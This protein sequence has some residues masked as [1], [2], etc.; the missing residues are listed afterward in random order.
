MQAGRREDS[1]ELARTGIAGLDHVVLGGLDRGHLYL[2]EG[3][4]GSGKT[5]LAMQ[6][7]MEGASAGERL[8]GFLGERLDL[9]TWSS[10]HPCGDS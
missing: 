9:P 10:N 3:T 7:L 4:P 5:T 8:S 6:F 2:L 1:K